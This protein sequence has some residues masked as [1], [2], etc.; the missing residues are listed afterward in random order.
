MGLFD[1]K[2]KTAG[3][4]PERLLIGCVAENREPYRTEALYLFRSIAESGGSLNRAKRIAYFVEAA[5]AEIVEKLAAL[6]VIVKIV[7]RFDSRCPHANKLMM[8]D[9]GEDYDIFLSLDC[10]CVVTKDFLPLLDAG[11]VMAKPAD[12]DPFESIAPW[13]TLF[14][15]FNLSL[16]K[17]RYKTAFSAREMV[18]YFNSGAVAIP[19]RFMPDLS[20]K[21]KEAVKDLLGSYDRLPSI[22]PQRFFTDQFALAVALHSGK[23]PFKPLPLEMNFPT[24]T[25]VHP[26]FRPE[27]LEPYM[28]HYHHRMSEKGI[29][30]CAYGNVN[31]AINKLNGV[32][33]VPLPHFSGKPAGTGLPGFDNREFWEARYATDPGLG[34]GV[35]SRGEVLEYKRGLIR[36]VITRTNPES[37]LDVGCGDIELSKDL[38]VK[39]Y[40]GLDLSESVIERNRKIRPDWKFDSGDLLKIA[41]AED[42]SSDMVVC[43]DVLIHEPDRERYYGLIETLVRSTKKTGVVAGFELPPREGFRSDITF[44]HEPL[45]VTLKRFGASD[46]QVIGYYRDVVMVRYG[47]KGKPGAAAKSVCILG[48]HRSGTSAIARAVNL[49]GVY[50]GE[51]ADLMAAAPDNPKG[52]WERNDIVELDDRIL[53][54]LKMSWDTPLPPPGGWERSG[55]MKEYR[56]EIKALIREKLSG[57]RFWAWKDPR[58][59]VLFDIWREVIEELGDE[60]VCLFAV[61]NPLDVARSL[62]KRDKFTME[63]SYGI[64]FNYNITALKAMK[65]LKCAFLSYDR[66]LADWKKELKRCAAGLD[67]PWPE[68]ETELTEKMS[69]FISPELRHSYSG[70]DEL[71]KT[72]A[73]TPVIELYRQLEVRFGGSAPVLMDEDFFS[74]IDQMYEEF[75]S[76]AAFFR[77]DIE[78]KCWF[79]ENEGTIEEKNGIIAEKERRIQELLNSMSWKITAPLRAVFRRKNTKR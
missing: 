63:K 29:D 68:D 78:T 27:I 36:K 17:A 58:T 50:L 65:G 25:P 48:M 34:S 13:K 42:L 57:H 32:L 31:A 72:G 23:F 61:R 66:F 55:K 75:S 39:K 21:W 5:D 2:K 35:G 9:D 56:D 69:E 24:H 45:T 76:Y 37:M 77:E 33:A 47:V 30:E 70:L 49:L 71:K 12:E 14:K 60:L 3:V 64:W 26:S 51:D 41:G 46:I 79:M 18:P 1:G 28:L 62:H 74:G 40:R 59:T 20:S 44:Y 53:A 6:G 7:G 4:A 16:P 54:G 38:P 52:Y 19:K 22:S 10:D 15:H 73:P 67:I 11:A 8:L 43:L